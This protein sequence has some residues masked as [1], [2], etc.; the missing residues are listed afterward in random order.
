[1]LAGR[2]VDPRWIP[3]DPLMEISH[4]IR[5]QGAL[6]CGNCHGP[7][8]VMDWKALG[9]TDAEAAKLADVESPSRE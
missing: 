1:M 5:K 4:A 9:Y 8:G 2:K 7:A 3:T 6:T